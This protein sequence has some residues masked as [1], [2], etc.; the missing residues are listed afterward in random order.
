MLLQMS[1]LHSFYGQVVFHCMC[2]CVW[3]LS[4]FSHS[5]VAGYLGCFHILAIVNSAAMNIR[6][7]VSF[8][9]MVFCRCMPTSGIAGSY[10]NSIFTLLRNLY[11][12]F[13]SGCINLHSYQHCTSFPFSPHP[14]Q[15]LPTYLFVCLFSAIP[16]AL[17]ILVAWPGIKP[18]PLQW[19]HRVLTTG[20][21]GKSL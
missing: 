5:S 3:H 6:V 8:R 17:R 16:Q 21:P 12:V 9:I 11:T 7:H 13:H 15:H 20:P 4:F 14:C 18:M 19:K 10:S 1:K 2:M